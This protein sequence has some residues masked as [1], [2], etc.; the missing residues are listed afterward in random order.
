[1]RSSGEAKQHGSVPKKNTEKQ[2][3]TVQRQSGRKSPTKPVDNPPKE[4]QK[5]TGPKKTK[6]PILAIHKENF[7][8]LQFKS[9]ITEI[10]ELPLKFVLKCIEGVYKNRFLFINTTPDGEIFGSG[11]AK[12]YGLTLQIEGAGLDTKHAQ[13]KFDGFKGFHV[14]DYGSQSGTWMNI[15]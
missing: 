5:E 9:N 14:V 8:I 12:T 11:D 3:T 7:D 4:V 2:D 15:P 1:M 6:Y 10:E 13:L